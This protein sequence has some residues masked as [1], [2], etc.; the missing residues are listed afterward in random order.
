MTLAQKFWPQDYVWKEGT[1]VFLPFKNDLVR[2]KI[3]NKLQNF[4]SDTL[5]FTNRLDKLSILGKVVQIKREHP[6]LREINANGKTTLQ[7]QYVNCISQEN[8]VKWLIC[9]KRLSKP[10][11]ISDE[12]RI[13][14][15][16]CSVTVAIPLDMAQQDELTQTGIFYTF[17][18]TN[19]QNGFP[20]LFD[21]DFILNA[22]RETISWDRPWNKWLLSYSFVPFLECFE[23]VL[24]TDPYSTNALTLQSFFGC[25][26]RFDKCRSEYT[27]LWNDFFSK[28]KTMKFLP[29]S[30]ELKTISEALIAD[31]SDLDFFDRAGF[32]FSNIVLRKFSNFL[33]SYKSSH[34]LGFKFLDADVWTAI[35]K[36]HVQNRSNPSPTW[37]NDLYGHLHT[38]SFSWQNSQMLKQFSIVLTQ[39]L[40]LQKHFETYL[41]LTDFPEEWKKFLLPQICSVVHSN[42]TNQDFLRKTLEVGILSQSEFITK[43]IKWLEKGQ[44]IEGIDAQLRFELT[45]LVF[46]EIYNQ[47]KNRWWNNPFSTVENLILLNDEGQNIRWAPYVPLKFNS[48]QWNF[49]FGCDSIA[50]LKNDKRFNS[51]YHFVASHFGD[52]LKSEYFINKEHCNWIFQSIFKEP[53][54]LSPFCDINNN[55]VRSSIYKPQIL[56]F[57]H[58][59]LAKFIDWLSLTP[60]LDLS[61]F[62]TEISI[63]L[64]SN[65]SVKGKIYAF[66]SNLCDLLCDRVCVVNMKFFSQLSYDGKRTLCKLFDVTNVVDMTPQERAVCLVVLLKQILR[67]DMGNR[68]QN[69]QDSKFY[70]DVLDQLLAEHKMHR[71]DFNFEAKENLKTLILMKD[72]SWLDQHSGLNLFLSSCPVFVGK[73]LKLLK[74]CKIEEPFKIVTKSSLA[75]EPL[76]DVIANTS[77]LT[78]DDYLSL[79]RSLTKIPL[80]L[81]KESNTIISEI[82]PTLYTSIGAIRLLQLESLIWFQSKWQSIQSKKFIWNDFQHFNSTTLTG[83]YH[84]VCG[85]VNLAFEYPGLKEFWI[86]LGVSESM[87][88]DFDIAVLRELDKELNDENTQM[89]EIEIAT[90][91]K[92]VYNSLVRYSAFSHDV[93]PVLCKNNG[94]FVF[95]ELNNQNKPNIFLPSKKLSLGDCPLNIVY[96][97]PSNDLNLFKGYSS[98]G[99]KCVDDTYK[100]D[101]FEI[102]ELESKEK[103][104]QTEMLFPTPGHRKYALSYLAHLHSP[105]SADFAQRFVSFEIIR[106][107]SITNILIL[108]G[109]V[110]SNFPTQIKWTSSTQQH[111]KSNTKPNQIYVVASMNEEDVVK[112]V[113][114]L[115]LKEMGARDKL[116]ASLF[117]AFQTFKILPESALPSFLDVL[118]LSDDSIGTVNLNSGVEA[119]K[120]PQ[121]TPTKPP[122]ISEDDE[123]DLSFDLPLDFSGLENFKVA[124]PKPE[125]Q[126]AISSPS[127][128]ETDQAQQLTPQHRQRHTSDHQNRQNS[129]TK[130]S[131]SSGVVVGGNNNANFT[132]SPLRSKGKSRSQRFQV[133]SIVKAKFTLVSKVSKISENSQHEIF[134]L[135]GTSTPQTQ[136]TSKSIS[137][138]S[139]NTHQFYFS[140]SDDSNFNT[141]QNQRISRRGEQIVFETLR[142]DE[143]WGQYSIIWLNEEKEEGGNPDIVI[144][145]ESDN[146]IAYIEV[147]STRAQNKTFHLSGNQW[148]LSQEYGNFKM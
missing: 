15:K 146:V 25:F 7:I 35:I 122:R 5:L 100:D 139:T 83:L 85:N 13:D 92:F 24:K 26:S 121:Q 68:I 120:N 37:F 9:K 73:T 49:L 32:S 14:V 59:E 108:A 141:E 96:I 144:S 51:D 88:P 111:P 119:F 77:K 143:G 130:R 97:S 117:K 31:K 105:I 134:T 79:L 82:L 136:I 18:P 4:K 131:P 23:W 69:P 112:S 34:P 55:K 3:V 98:L 129:G 48:E 65:V 126:K 41:V 87:S 84:K 106:V 125:S 74:D 124:F 63:P 16:E 99:L 137:N 94:E 71:L 148:N 75:S 53:T 72:K 33:P 104:N 66:P 123:L 21:A 12:K 46:K 60:N 28:I 43:A 54:S 145:D 114:T 103:T 8:S 70:C 27:Y 127:K 91:A 20:F 67:P 42:I 115:I 93:F 58:S 138:N 147:K 135:Q 118:K 102:S 6:L 45:S 2:E 64:Q 76:F 81:S 110:T 19:Q 109:N 95:V 113:C 62:R 57:S 52:T 38:I 116:I 50:K 80:P 29:C 39:Q 90:A 86:R 133:S 44:E 40:Q 17:L 1:I 132:N 61:G 36:E 101:Y 10:S 140:P 47:P 107:K 56:S 22:S 89:N 78:V 30:S 11:N 128:V 142:K